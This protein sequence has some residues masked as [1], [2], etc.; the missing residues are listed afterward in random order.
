MHR[1]RKGRTF[2]KYP[3]APPPDRVSR[4][5]R[6]GLLKGGSERRVQGQKGRSGLSPFFVDLWLAMAWEAS[7]EV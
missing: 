3:P 5:Y 2:R 7:L 6:G 4:N 1:E